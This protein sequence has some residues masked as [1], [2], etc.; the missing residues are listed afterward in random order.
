MG[1]KLKDHSHY[2]FKVR[3]GN[4]TATL[5]FKDTK[6][7]MAWVEGAVVERRMFG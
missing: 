6:A 2:L 5:A 7:A 1:K 3:G 4:E